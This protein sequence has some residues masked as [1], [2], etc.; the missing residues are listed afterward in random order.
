MLTAPITINRW[1]VPPIL[2][3]GVGLLLL[4]SDPQGMH[5][6]PWNIGNQFQYM[7]ETKDKP[8]FHENSCI[9][10]HTVSVAL[11][12]PDSK[13][14]SVKKI[15]TSL[16]PHCKTHYT[17]RTFT[18]DSLIIQIEIIQQVTLA[19]SIPNI[20]RMINELVTES[21]QPWASKAFCTLAREIDWCKSRLYIMFGLRIIK[22]WRSLKWMCA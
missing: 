7:Q 22:T 10:R 8:I 17:T 16:P 6:S 4:V 15:G 13:L 14:N 3:D 1:W 19:V 12:N 9:P 18:W 11:I 2:Y 5:E 20:W 21:L